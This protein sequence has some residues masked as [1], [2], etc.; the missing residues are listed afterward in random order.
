M[1]LDYKTNYKSKVKRK[2]WITTGIMILVLL[3]ATGFILYIRQRSTQKSTD[4]AGWKN[5]F[6]SLE[7]GNPDAGK[8]GKPL[9]RQAVYLY[10]IGIA[11]ISLADVHRRFPHRGIYDVFKS[12]EYPCILLKGLEHIQ[13]LHRRDCSDGGWKNRYGYGGTSGTGI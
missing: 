11:R 8:Q 10:T 4:G 13:N 9:E 3:L 1:P 12:G 7:L 5:Y 2:R 6:Q